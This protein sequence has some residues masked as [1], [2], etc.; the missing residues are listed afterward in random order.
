MFSCLLQWVRLLRSNFGIDSA[1]FAMTPALGDPPWR[2]SLRS[3]LPGK[4]ISLRSISGIICTV[5]HGRG[6]AGLAAI[7][8]GSPRGVALSP[9]F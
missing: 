1:L 2:I 4:R 5:C 3:V 9:G 7:L 8:S 6:A